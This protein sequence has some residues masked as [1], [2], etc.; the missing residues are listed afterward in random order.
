MILRM[1][2]RAAAAY[3]SGEPPAIWE[4]EEHIR[5]RRI[6][7]DAQR[8]L[9]ECVQARGNCLACQALDQRS[10]LNQRPARRVDKH[11]PGRNSASSAAPIQWRW[12]A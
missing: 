7:G 8:L 4:V 6:D 2:S 5:L 9:G 1:T 3:M 12:Q 11:S 10:G